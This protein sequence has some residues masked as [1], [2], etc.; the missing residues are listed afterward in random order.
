VPLIEI[1]PQRFRKIQYERP[2]KGRNI[3]I[4]IEATGALDI[5]V[6]PASQIDKWK[7]GSAEYGG[8]GFLR[9]KTLQVKFGIG[10][11]FEDDWYLVLENKFDRPITAK[12]EVFWER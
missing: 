7:R 4:D 11:E 8:D 5:F 2:P 10:P 9:K 3:G 1:Q 6:V 12:Y